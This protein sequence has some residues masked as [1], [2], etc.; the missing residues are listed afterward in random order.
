MSVSTE[1]LLQV[2]SLVKEFPVRHERGRVVHA[3]TQVSFDMF[4]GETLGLIGE[5]G[6]G[7]TTVGRCIIGLTGATSGSIKL[8]GSEIVGLSARQM[9][10]LRSRIQ[11]VFQDPR[12][13]L[14]PRMR[15]GEIID[16]PIRFFTELSKPERKA[17]L[18]EVLDLVQLPAD[19]ADRY[20]V[21][22]SGGVQQRIGIARALAPNPE[23]VILDEPTSELDVSV[24]AEI[25]RLLRQL[26]QEL[27]IAYLFISHD[28]TAVREVSD[29]IA[30]MYLGE[31][32]EI[33]SASDIFDEQLHPYS[34]ALLASVL[35]PDPS[36]IPGEVSL[37]GEIPSPVDLPSGCFLHPRCPYRD[38]QCLSDHPDLAM[39]YGRDVR[40]LRVEG[41]KHGTVRARSDSDLVPS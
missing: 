19:V 21:E 26:Q 35:F 5:S 10:N 14:N 34:K 41:I 22:L 11:I 23:L 37:V 15:V 27:H 9:R 25:V 40:C 3:V 16:E 18:R 12:D 2:R 1:P 8:N 6:S 24:R 38:E 39:Q 36:R 7:K 32:V 20:P 33:A 13:S 17:R 30:I 31:V 29:R 4:R 28:L